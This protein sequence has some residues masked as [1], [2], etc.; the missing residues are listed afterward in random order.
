MFEV[1]LCGEVY[2]K[3]II[4]ADW[5]IRPDTP[6]C[7][8]DEDWI[9]TQYSQ[10]N[11]VANRAN[12][13]GCPVIIVGDLFHKPNVND[14]LKNL[15]IQVFKEIRVFAIAG[16]H[17]LPYHSFDNLNNSSIGVLFQTKVVTYPYFAAFSNFGE[18]VVNRGS[19]VLF[20][21][22]PI[23]ASEQDCPPDMKAKTALQVFDE[24][25]EA[26]WIFCGDIHRGYHVKKQGR[27]LIMAGC[28]NRQA[29]DYIDYE[30]VIWYVDTET[31]TVER[32][33]VPDDINMV[34]DE[35]IQE[36]NDRKDRISAFV[37]QVRNSKK[38]TLDFDNNVREALKE[39]DLSEG[40]INTVK[41]LME[42]V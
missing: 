30:P 40:A 2:V 22:E 28:L 1:C 8:K 10:M 37:S 35:H 6:R 17:C 25:P 9:D 18:K 5:H 24:Y 19:E 34:T 7:R 33:P 20:L 4:T 27:H 23:F 15:F 14:L 31:E 29:S 16:N 13:Y 42:V 11:F 38:V 12:E 21:H 39:S 26:K 36:K 32:I 41:E 3:L